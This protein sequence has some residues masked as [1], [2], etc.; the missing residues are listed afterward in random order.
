[1][2]QDSEIPSLKRSARS[3]SSPGSESEQKNIAYINF[4]VKLKQNDDNGP[5]LHVRSFRLGDSLVELVSRRNFVGE[6][7][8]DFGEAFGENADVVLKFALFLLLIQDLLVQLI[9]LCT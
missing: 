9:T 8:V 6:A 5:H 2:N 4:F 3:V 1:M 7:L